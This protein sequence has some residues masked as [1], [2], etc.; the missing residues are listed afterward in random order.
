[1]VLFSF[2]TPKF[3]ENT[4]CFEKATMI[5]LLLEN[6][7]SY[8]HFRAFVLAFLSAWN[9]SP[10]D[11]LMT[12]SCPSG[13][14]S[15]VICLKKK[16]PT[17]TLSTPPHTIASPHY[18]I[19]IKIF[20][21]KLGLVAQACSPSCSIEYC[22]RIESWRPA[23][24]FFIFLLI[25]WESHRIYCV[26]SHPHF[27]PGSLLLPYLHNFMF[28]FFIEN[29]FLS[30]TIHVKS[31]LLSLCSSQLPITYPLPEI[32]SLFISLQKGELQETTVKYSKIR[33]NKKRQKSSFGS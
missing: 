26:H 27:L 24:E 13:L 20:L 3:K 11:L 6:A 25:L 9:I 1:M 16:L 12:F 10:A 8:S 19:S 21:F 30:H 31:S 32:Y 17:S 2:I 22:R 29:R 15:N 33:Y 18:L 28:L 4:V 7:R 14:S 23:G 5:F